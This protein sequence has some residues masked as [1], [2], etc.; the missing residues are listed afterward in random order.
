ML[1][2]Q[3]LPVITGVADKMTAW[4]RKPENQAQLK[5]MVNSFI[6]MAKQLG[7]I[8]K[9]FLPVINAAG[10]FTAKHP[11]IVRMVGTLI[12]MRMAIRLISFANPVRGIIGFGRRISGLGA[13]GS[14]AGAG[15][16]AGLG[17]A[18]PRASAALNKWRGGM[19]AKFGAFG[20]IAAAA[21]VA[22][23]GPK[24]VGDMTTI[25]NSIQGG[26]NAGGAG[27]GL[28]RIGA[29]ILGGVAGFA[30]GGPAGMF[31][32]AGIANQI[33]GPAAG[34]LGIGNKA[35]GRRVY[36]VVLRRAGQPDEIH[37]FNTKGEADAFAKQARRSSRATG[38]STM[39][40]YTAPATDTPGARKTTG[41][42]A[43][44]TP[45]SKLPGKLLGAANA[46]LAVFAEAKARVDEADTR[47]WARGIDPNSAKGAKERMRRINSALSTHKSVRGKL[48]GLARQAAKQGLHSTVSRILSMIRTLDHD[49][50]ELEAQRNEAR[51]QSKDSTVDTQALLDETNRRLS[52]SQNKAAAE[53]AF[54]RAAF[55]AGDIGAGGRN[56]WAA[57]G[58]QGAGS[59]VMGGANVNVTINSLTPGDSKTQ[60]VIAKTVVKAV[61]GQGSTRRPRATTHNGKK[62]R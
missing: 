24:I 9:S 15:I 47:M 38:A 58:G 55:T 16:A 1:G 22:T 33:A 50:M 62:R 18:W 10:R 49:A 56:A 39:P 4:L 40:A 44:A 27:K 48:H 60:S 45:A 53:G 34:A 30:L 21:F 42:K 32:G 11:D 7:A 5:S 36:P 14:R 51:A 26:N 35:K 28:F 54:I 59:R 19:S 13:L 37:N 31:V 6:S 2:R 17:R 46:G 20:F 25:M 57:A 8:A 23:A 29:T 41:G 43:K 3:L 61:G 12:A 52:N